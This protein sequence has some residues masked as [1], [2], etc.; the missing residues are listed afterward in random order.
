MA[1]KQA[2]PNL[3]SSVT[4]AVLRG[5]GLRSFRISE[6]PL[7]FGKIFPRSLL[8]VDLSA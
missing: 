7:S 6:T 8:G 5:K 4:L 3:A 2:C 1:R